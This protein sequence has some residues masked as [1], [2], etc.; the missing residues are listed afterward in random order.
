MRTS[1]AVV[2]LTL[3]SASPLFAQNPVTKGFFTGGAGFVFFKNVSGFSTAGDQGTS[4]I[5]A[6]LGARIKGH[7]MLIGNGGWVR[8]LQKGIQPLLVATTNTIY[9]V[10]GISTTGTGTMPVWYG[11]G[12]LSLNGPT[13]GLWTPYVMGE[14]GIARLNPTIELQYKSGTIPGQTT[15]PPTVGSDQTSLFEKLGY[16]RAPGTSTTQMYTAVDTDRLMEV[17]RNAHPRA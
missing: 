8:N 9:N 13:L 6:A 15:A 17:Y 2:I 12:G 3:V 4:D 5:S 1:L 11:E 16:F 14:Y 10:H 7:V